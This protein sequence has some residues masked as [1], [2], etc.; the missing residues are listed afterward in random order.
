MWGFCQVNFDFMCYFTFFCILLSFFGY[1]YSFCNSYDKY[2]IPCKTFVRSM[3]NHLVCP[4]HQESDQLLIFIMVPKVFLLLSLLSSLAS[5][6]SSLLLSSPS[7]LSSGLDLVAPSPLG[8]QKKPDV[9]FMTS[10]LQDS[11][12]WHTNTQ[13]IKTFFSN[14]LLHGGPKGLGGCPVDQPA[15][16]SCEGVRF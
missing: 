7:C 5:S 16:S 2:S 9:A 6:T 10:R 12:G 3:L 4:Y 11:L 13:N 1:L 15:E 8:L 14:C